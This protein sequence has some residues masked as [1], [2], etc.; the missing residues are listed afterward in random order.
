MQSGLTGKQRH[1]WNVIELDGKWYAV[2]VTWDDN[3]ATQKKGIEFVSHKYFNAPEEIMKVTHKWDEINETEQIERWLD[4]KYFYL[5][6]EVT[7]TAF[8]YY[9]NTV[10][11]AIGFISTSLIHNRK[12]IRVMAYRN[13]RRFDD[14]KLVNIVID[15]NLTRARKGISYYNIYQRHGNYSF[16]SIEVKSVRR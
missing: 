9:F 11:D 16:Y 13:D 3:D 1:V 4:D 2:D 7:D 14:I 10:K 5:T 15:S 12:S 8:G 6:P